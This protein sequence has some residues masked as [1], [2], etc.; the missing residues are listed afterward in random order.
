MQQ[1]QAQLARPTTT[2]AATTTTTAAAAVP[3]HVVASTAA[4]A[5]S[6]GGGVDTTDI[7]TLNDALGSAGVDL[8]VRTRTH[9]FF[10][11]LT[12]LPPHILF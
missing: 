8:R 3:A 5:T 4:A 12:P 7:A 11:Y 6:S 2:A 10:S 9:I 1:A